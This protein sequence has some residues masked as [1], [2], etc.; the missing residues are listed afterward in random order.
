[1]NTI[2]IFVCAFLLSFLLSESFAGGEFLKNINTQKYKLVKGDVPNLTPDDKVLV[3]HYVPWDNFHATS[4]ARII[5]NSGII[6]AAK[7]RVETMRR[8]IATAQRAGI[9]GFWVDLP[10]GGNP[11]RVSLAYTDVLEDLLKA[12]EGSS[13]TVAGCLDFG[14]NDK[15]LENVANNI[16]RL[17]KLSR[18]YPNY[19][20]VNGK[21]VVSTYCACRRP[22]NEWAEIK[23]ILSKS[24]DDIFLVLDMSYWMFKVLREDVVD[25]YSKVADMIYIFEDYGSTAYSVVPNKKRLSH[26][27][28]FGL[29]NKVARLNSITAAKTIT[30][31]YCGGWLANQHNS[32]NPHR[33]F[34]L[35]LESFSAYDKQYCNWVHLTTWND[36]IET[37]VHPLMWDFATQMDLL[38][39]FKNEIMLE[40]QSPKKRQ[41]RLY[42]GYFREI[43][44]GSTLRIETLV[45]PRK[46][47]KEIEISGRLLDTDGKE[48]AKMQPQKFTDSKLSTA[49]WL[50]PTDNAVHSMAVIPEI[51]TTIDGVS[52]TKKLP[53]TILKYGWVQNNSTIKIAFTTPIEIESSVV[54]CSSATDKNLINATVKFASPEK[55]KRATLYR[56]DLKLATLL[57]ADNRKQINLFML[58]KKK[59]RMKMTLE[60]AEF[61]FIQ[62][63]PRT[64]YTKTTFEAYNENFPLE[65]QIK[66]ADNAVCKVKIDD[67]PEE[68]INLAELTKKDYSTFCNKMLTIKTQPISI[69]K[70]DVSEGCENGEF[71]VSVYTRSPRESDI[72]YVRFETE[73]GKVAFSKLI[74]PFSSKKNVEMNILKTERT[75]DYTVNTT[76]FKTKSTLAPNEIV[77]RS[78]NPVVLRSALYNFENGSEDSLGERPIPGG[79]WTGPIWFDQQK[80]LKD[81]G[82]YGKKYLSLE[83][84]NELPLHIRTFPLTACTIQFD[85]RINEMPKKKSRLFGRKSWNWG[86]AFDIYVDAN[87][88]IEASKGFGRPTE[89][90]YVANTI[91]SSDTSLQLG[92]WTRITLTFDEKTAVLYINGK[93]TASAE[94]PLN[95][96]FGHES[97]FLGD[98]ST[99]LVVDFDNL[100]LLSYPIAE[101][102][103][104]IQ[105]SKTTTD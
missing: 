69:A 33:C 7:N 78:V 14:G 24:G 21:P 75:L 12:S 56:N 92:K 94:I 32:Y 59:A 57:D 50:I 28:L 30:P 80:L 2:K 44:A 16:R 40:K 74:A 61:S 96:G 84:G 97:P 31:G 15:N 103:I 35:M 49:E 104:Q 105:C 23:N 65:A 19:M 51:T 10:G 58:K 82:V 25:T 67:L 53:A 73:N 18:K 95:R 99:G 41:P 54:V 13:F 1:M 34:D 77:K 89:A 47:A 90:D 55:V 71:S 27:E 26:E 36:L 76:G 68:I 3:A 45:L 93:K 46:N 87:G 98:A 42:F 52:E 91:I 85:V 101:T 79:R 88:K 48:I 4:K 9:T 29:L 6:P 39:W 5:Y 38:R 11:K 43:L 8:D 20:R 81:G 22:A 60:N 63:I 70:N 64:S 102:E 86:S 100:M 72:F 66:F 62:D 83:K 37:A 17:V